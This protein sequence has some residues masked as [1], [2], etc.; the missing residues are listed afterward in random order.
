M[1]PV[2]DRTP[3]RGLSSFQSTLRGNGAAAVEVPLRRIDDL[4]SRER[5]P[6]AFVKIDVEGHEL[7]C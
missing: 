5:T 3:H 7:Q 1:T 6:V 4:I 2:H